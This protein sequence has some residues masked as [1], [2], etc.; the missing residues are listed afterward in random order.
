VRALLFLARE[1]ESQGKREEADA[2]HLQ[3]LR[4]APG[5]IETLQQVAGLLFA[6]RR[7]KGGPCDARAG[8]QRRPRRRQ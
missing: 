4:L 5:D 2:A 1:L 8:G 3:A 6:H 7:P